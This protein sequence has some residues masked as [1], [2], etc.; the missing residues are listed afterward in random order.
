MKLILILVLLL[1][2]C[3]TTV[4]VAQKFP[5]AP[6]LLQEPCQ[7]LQK[8]EGSKITIVDYTKTVTENYTRYHECSAKNSAWIDWYKQQKQVFEKD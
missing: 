1:A 2:G 7:Q 5:A 6:E 8:L 4:P 3:S